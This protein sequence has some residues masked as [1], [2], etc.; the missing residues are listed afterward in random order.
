MFTKIRRAMLAATGT[1][2]MLAAVAPSAHAG[3]L[4]LA[5]GSCGLTESQPFSGFGDTNYY[6]PVPGGTFEAGSS[7]WTLKNGAKAVAG[8]YNSLQSLQLPAGSS[9]TS[10]AAC[11]GLDHPSARLFVR[12]TG[13]STSR[14]HVTATYRILLGL[15]ISID[16]GYITAT[17]TWQPSTSLNMGLLSNLA[18]SL[19][20]SQS[21]ISFTFKPADST[22]NWQIDD[23]Y[24][25]PFRRG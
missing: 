1:V 18:G 12:N 22:G 10:P 11:T 4:S 8:G 7:A 2:A 23:A 13:S 20:L 17:G 15:P 16:L 25:D 5:P 14:L 24:L 9:A 21:T 3:L 6:T 19:T